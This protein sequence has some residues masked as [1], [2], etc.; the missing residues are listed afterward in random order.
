[1]AILRLLIDSVLVIKMDA[2][3]VSNIRI[4]K[5]TKILNNSRY[6]LY[7]SYLDSSVPFAKGSNK[8]FCI[9][10]LT[11]WGVKKLSLKKAIELYELDP[12]P[13]DL[14]MDRLNNLYSNI[15][16]EGRTRVCCIKLGWSVVGSEKLI[17]FGDSWFSAK[18]IKVVCFF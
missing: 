3:I 18:A 14:T 15:D 11:K 17:D 16:Y 12:K 13:E 1:L 6:N 7:S 10:S 5:N 4:E 2:E 9:A 8:L